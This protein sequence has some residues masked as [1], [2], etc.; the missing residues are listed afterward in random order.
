MVSVYPQYVNESLNVFIEI[1]EKP[2][3]DNFYRS[4]VVIIAATFMLVAVVF[5]SLVRVL[6]L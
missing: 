1:D 3:A 2:T 4:F 5:L 6:R